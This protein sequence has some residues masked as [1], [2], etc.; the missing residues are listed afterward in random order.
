[1]KYKLAA[2]A[3]DGKAGDEVDLDHAVPAVQLNVDAGVLVQTGTLGAMNCPA[4]EAEGKK[5]HTK[6]ADQAEVD[7]HY[8]EKHPGLVAPEWRED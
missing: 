3:Y 6:L 2:D 8:G 7:A 5:R 4:C 1:M